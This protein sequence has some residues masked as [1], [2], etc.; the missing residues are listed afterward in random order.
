[1]RAPGEG[2]LAVKGAA[3]DKILQSAL[4]VFARQGYHRAAVDDIVRES[5]TSKGAVYHH[6]PTKEALFLA[7]VEDFAS[8]L[9]DA[10][11]AAIEQ[12]H[13][14]VGR[15]EGALRAGLETFARHRE[16]SRIILLESASVGTGYQAKRAEIHG[17]FAT[18]IQNY[19][20]QAVVDGTI[21]AVDT[22]IV[23]RAWLGAINEL[24]IESLSPGGPDLLADVVPTLAP[25][26]LRSIGVRSDPIRPGPPARVSTPVVMD[27]AGEAGTRS[28]ATSM[29][30]GSGADS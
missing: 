14:A 13:S 3:R 20:D 27:G 24:V 10:V 12:S 7:L 19:L 9:A 29:C 5:G 4:A 15:V 16:L 6:F 28:G 22:R 23:T 21:P 18:L 25:M 2:P 30:S 17:R 1:M 26:L 11:S 8:H